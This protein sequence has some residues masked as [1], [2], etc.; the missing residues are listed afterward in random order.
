[1][2]Q[3]ALSLLGHLQITLD[4]IPLSAPLTTKTQALLAYMAVE[5]DSPHRREK[6][7]G[8]LWPDQP[9]EAARTDLRQ[10]LSQLRHALGNEFS[11]FLCVTPQTVQ[12]NPASNYALDVA[13][14]VALIQACEKHP[15]RRRETCRA[16]L[17]RLE[18]AAA[19]YRGDLLAEFSIKDSA[20]FE[21]WTLVRRE[22]LSRMALAALHSLAEYYLSQAEYERAEQAAR[23]QI[24]LDPFREN[25]YRQVMR[26]LALT[27]QRNAAGSCFR[28]C[29]Q[30]LAQELGA[31]PE[32]ETLDLHNQI[33]AGTL[34]QLSLVRQ[35]NWPAVAQLTSFI[36]REREL[37]QIA[38]YLASPHVRLLTL[39]GPGGIGKTRLALQ[40][41]A[42]EAFAFR[43]GACFVPLAAV[44]A[45]DL[46]AQAIA[47]ALG[48]PPAGA[49]DPRASLLQY[50]QAGKR[51]LLL[52]LDNLE[53]LLDIAELLV[54]IFDQAPGVTVLATSRERLNLRVEHVLTIYGLPVESAGP[55]LE[56]SP[57]VQLFLQNAQRASAGFALAHEDLACV[58][59]V[60][61]LVEGM[62]LAI[63][64]A[65][66]WTRTLPCQDI[67][68]EIRSLDFLAATTRDAPERHRSVR[69]TFDSSWRLLAETE[70]SAFCRLSVFRGGFRREAALAVAEAPLPLLSALVDKSLLRGSP[71]GRYEIHEL[72]RQYGE[73]KLDLAPGEKRQALNLHSDYYADFMQQTSE[74]IARHQPDTLE[75]I[76]RE[77]GNLRVAWDWAVDQGNAQ[78]IGKLLPGLFEFYRVRGWFPESEAVLERAA[79]ILRAREQNLLLGQVLVRRGQCCLG[80]SKIAQAEEFAQAGLSILRPFS[81]RKE[82]ALA[83]DILGDA[84]QKLGR[85]VQATQLHRESLAIRR[86]MGDHVGMA[87]TLNF[88]GSHADQRGEYRE[89]EEY[90][91]ESLRIG[92]EIG[93][94]WTIAH[95]LI[96]L[97]SLAFE[98]GEFSQARLLYERS[99]PLLREMGDQWGLAD[100]LNNLGS[101]ARLTGEHAEARRLYLENLA[102]R[103]EIGHRWGIAYGMIQL[104][105]VEE[106]LARYAEAK[107]LFLQALAIARETGHRWGIPIALISLGNVLD[108]LGEHEQ[109][110][111]CFHQAVGMAMQGSFRPLVLEALVGLVSLSIRAGDQERAL[112]LLGFAQAQPTL[113]RETK[114]RLE[115]FVLPRL[116]GSAYRETEAWARGRAMTVDEAVSLACGGGEEMHSLQSHQHDDGNGIAR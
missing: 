56:D 15:H 86:E 76:G 65:A 54:A 57:A 62:P 29:R 102:I 97:G 21:E 90:W 81:E 47:H 89:A 7:A 116:A 35:R 48:L 106:Q 53:H 61:Q 74:R 8:L 16:C 94:T 3:L 30:L 108:A 85:D 37:A 79:S 115:R 110:Q 42:Q 55:G 46:V 44:R 113:R 104:A 93:D 20:A 51:D 45:P 40:A 99:L 109:A 6:L 77:I 36:G 34:P 31:Q 101:A 83:L 22:Q 52:V 98:R 19:L 69:A 68:H 50:L 39:V 100:C 58:A 59:R 75:Q 84:V 9:E 13:E 24:E 4:G 18:R 25:A 32:Q 72:L 41:A 14:L 63:E 60:C 10:T 26:T 33:Q 92:E 78:A 23:R 88:L 12:F 11:S 107:Q 96:N 27:G 87:R 114:H 38:Q 1:M 80:L 66:A 5:A 105:R 103:R 91:R 70:Q 49:G 73:E 111:D 67:V 71:A 82:I 43:D 95:E 2:A 64:L 17:A 28:A 112:T